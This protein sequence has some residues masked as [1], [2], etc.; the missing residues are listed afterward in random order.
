MNIWDAVIAAILAA[1]LFWAIRRTHKNKQAG[2]TGCCA[3]CGHA[4]ACRQGKENN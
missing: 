1:G 4:C 3:S 2:C